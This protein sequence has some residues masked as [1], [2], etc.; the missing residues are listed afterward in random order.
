VGVVVAPMMEPIMPAGLVVP[1]VVMVGI[2]QIRMPELL[3]HLVRDIP[4]AELGLAEHPGNL[5]QVEVVLEVLVALVLARAVI[6]TV[7]MAEMVEVVFLQASP[8]LP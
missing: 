1:V 3:G 5:L 6:P 4:V 7:V 2:L 8:A